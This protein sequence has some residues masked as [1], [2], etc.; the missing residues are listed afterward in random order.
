MADEI[1]AKSEITKDPETI[2]G[3]ITKVFKELVEVRVVTVVGDVTVQLVSEDD[4][5]TIKTKLTSIPESAKAFVTIFDLI[6]G[7]V[8]NVIPPSLKD[9]EQLRAFHADQ[10]ERSMKVLPDNIR[11][12]VE[13]GKSIINELS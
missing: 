8:T 3:T 4:G 9:D 7:D 10:V 6:D 12:L 13:L 2:K 1:G 5:A 11:A